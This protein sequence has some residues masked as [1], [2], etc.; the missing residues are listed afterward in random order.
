MERL[1]VRDGRG[2]HEPDAGG[3][4]GD[5]GRDEHRVQAAADLIGARVRP[6]VVGR[7]LAERVL[8]GDEVDQ[9]PFGFQ[10]EL[11]PVTGGEELVRCGVRLAPGGRVPSC[12]VKRDGQVQWRGH[13]SSRGE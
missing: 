9:S 13:A 1:G 12:S 5:P 10:G 3:Q 6:V 11:S 8:D 4:R 7:L 2:G